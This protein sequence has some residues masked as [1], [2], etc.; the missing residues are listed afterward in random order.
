MTWLVLTEIACLFAISLHISFPR[1]A[2]AVT[3]RFILVA[4]VWAVS[5]WPTTCKLGQNLYNAV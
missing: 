1:C 2:R 3:I 4:V 5:T